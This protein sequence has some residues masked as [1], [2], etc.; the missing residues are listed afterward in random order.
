MTLVDIISA[1]ST[2]L[3]SATRSLIRCVLVTV[4]C[5]TRPD[6]LLNRQRQSQGKAITQ[7]LWDAFDRRNLS[8][9]LGHA[10][11]DYFLARYPVTDDRSLLKKLMDDVLPATVY[12]EKVLSGNATRIYIANSGCQ[13]FDIASRLERYLHLVTRS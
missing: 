12:D 11:Q 8:Y 6:R 7:T 9:P 1:S 4:Q 10:P 13:R 5:Q 3:E 2:M